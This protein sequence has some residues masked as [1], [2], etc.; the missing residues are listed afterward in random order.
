M[1]GGG[2][3]HSPAAGGGEGGA[4]LLA[5]SPAHQPTSPRALLEQ[6]PGCAPIQP[7]R[8]LNQTLAPTDQSIDRWRMAGRVPKCEC[9]APKQGTHPL[10][11]NRGHFS[12]RPFARGGGGVRGVS[13]VGAGAGAAPAMPDS[14]APKGGQ[15]AA[16]RAWAEGEWPCDRPPATG[17][18]PPSVDKQCRQVPSEHSNRCIPPEVPTGTPDGPL[19]H[20]PRDLL[21]WPYPIAGDPPD[22][23]DHRG[24]NPSLP[25][26]ECHARSA[27]AVPTQCARSAKFC[28]S[29]TT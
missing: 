27:H 13:G 23:R 2:G 14:W 6:I 17:A 28:M 19:W 10:P 12:G 21:E 22:Q 11:Q 3:K 5:L 15:G 24:K 9:G 7:F 8:T 4:W 25:F 18:P 26:G 16:Q 1:A 20:P 29:V